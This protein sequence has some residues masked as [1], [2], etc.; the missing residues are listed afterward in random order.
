MQNSFAK[1]YEK[2]VNEDGSVTITVK[3]RRYSAHNVQSAVAIFCVALPVA[4]IFGVFALLE[5][6]QVRD[7]SMLF[8]IAAALWVAIVVKV[9]HKSALVKVI[10]NSGL[11]FDGNQVPFSDIDNIG[12][13]LL[14]TSADAKGSSYVFVHT[15]GREVRVTPFL[16]DAQARA[17]CREIISAGNVQYA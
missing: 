14:T 15:Q 2:V 3:G 1:T 6:F 13:S 7:G 4:L 8:L 16:D 17:V 12:T 11:I 10:P 9:A 5:I